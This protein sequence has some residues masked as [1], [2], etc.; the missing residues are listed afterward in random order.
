MSER[1]LTK[2]LCFK[3]FFDQFIQLKWTKAYRRAKGKDLVKDEVL[4]FEKQR[5]TPLKYSREVWDNTVE[6]MKKMNEIKH[7]REAQDIKNR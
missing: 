3:H 4:S 2:S 1:N 5:D 6:S 7:R